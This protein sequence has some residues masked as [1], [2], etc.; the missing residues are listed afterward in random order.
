MCFWIKKSNRKT[1]KTSKQGHRLICQ[2]DKDNYCGKF[3]NEIEIKARTQRNMSGGYRW[4]RMDK[5]KNEDTEWKVNS[6][7]G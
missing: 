4:K 6:V 3:Q 1:H 5:Q 7:F 2:Q